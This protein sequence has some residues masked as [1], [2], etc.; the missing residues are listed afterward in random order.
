MRAA[1]CARLERRLVAVSLRGRPFRQSEGSTWWWVTAVSRPPVVVVTMLPGRY[2][3]SARSARRCHG[4]MH[5]ATLSP[6]V[7]GDRIGEHAMRQ[8]RGV[9]PRPKAWV[10]DPR[11]DGLFIFVR[12]RPD[13]DQPS[14]IAW[15]GRVLPAYPLIERPRS[16]RRSLRAS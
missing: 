8:A 12:L 6:E 9:L 3:C 10:S 2:T 11:S 1:S 15:L 14:A 7:R 16:F 13:I 5:P 4:P